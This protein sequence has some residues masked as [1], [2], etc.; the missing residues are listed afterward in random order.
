[1]DDVLNI[2]ETY[3]W[4]YHDDLPD[5]WILEGS[6]KYRYIYDKLIWDVFTS[7]QDI[8][9]QILTIAVVRIVNFIY[10]KFGFDNNSNKHDSLL[11]TQLKQNNLLDLRA[12]LNMTLPFIDDD[13]GTK[14]KKLTKL[15]DLFI[16][17]DASGKYMYTTSQYNRCI[18][19]VKNK[20][21]QYFLRPFKIEYF[22]NHLELLLASIDQ[23]SNKLYVNW[24]DVIPITMNEYKTSYV[25]QKLWKNFTIIYILQKTE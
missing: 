14:R 19:Y 11:W 13:D 1:M 3:N 24:V 2:F 22:L 25:Y 9:K 5:R 6:E 20:R 23:S 10:V 17:K 16:K 21:V 18:R 7:L 12:I 4:D 15:E 8:D